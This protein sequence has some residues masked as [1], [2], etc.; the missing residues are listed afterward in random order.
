ML[1]PVSPYR[2]PAGIAA[3]AFCVR[4]DATT[5]DW[6]I[7]VVSIEG[8]IP[9]G[10]AGRDHA[11]YITLASLE[12]MARQDAKCLVLD[13]SECDYSWGNSIDRVFDAVRR[14]YHYEWYDLDMMPPVKVVVSKRS[15][16]LRSLLD[17]DI[18]FDDIESAI[19]SCSLDLDKWNTD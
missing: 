10:S 16:G 14:L 4:D 19:A 15:A 9:E 11:E 12:A 2:A 8:T 1:Q 7:S 6:A 13:F 18:I 17:P 3:R 5:L